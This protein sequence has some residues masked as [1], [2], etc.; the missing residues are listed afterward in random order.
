MKFI[1]SII[2]SLN[3]LYT[4]AQ[5]SASLVQKPLLDILH[6][7]EKKYH[8]SFSFSH[9]LI[10]KKTTTVQLH[11]LHLGQFLSSVAEECG[12]DFEEIDEKDYVIT[13][14]PPR[15]KNY[16]INLI[17]E[18]NQPIYGVYATCGNKMLGSIS[19]DDGQMKFS[20]KA[21]DGDSI[22]FHMIGYYEQTI[23]FSF[24]STQTPYTTIQL[25]ADHHAL[26]LDVVEVFITEGI[27]TGVDAHN[28]MIKTDELA[29]LPGESG[30]DVLNSIKLM[31]GVRSPDS[32]I[33]NLFIRGSSPDQSTIIY[34]NIPLYHRGHYFGA[35]SPFN[36]SMIDEIDIY[37]GGGTSDYG[38]KVGGIIDIQSSDKAVDSTTFTVGVNS[39]YL[40]GHTKVPLKKN[41]VAL[42]LS[43]RRSLPHK[44]NLPK[45]QA[46]NDMVFKASEIERLQT[47]TNDSLNALNYTFEDYKSKLIWDP[48]QD[49]HLSFSFIHVSN[50]LEF[51]KTKS[52]TVLDKN[53]SGFSNFGGSFRWK[54]H[55]N[56][57]WS[58][59]LVFSAQEYD[60]ISTVTEQLNDNTQFVQIDNRNRIKEYTAKLEFSKYLNDIDYIDFGFKQAHKNIT[61]FNKTY[62]GNT[63]ES[64][65]DSLSNIGN[66]HT[67]Y[68][69]YHFQHAKNFHFTLGTRANYFSEDEKFNIEPRFFMSYKLNDFVLLK[70]SY[71]RNKQF[72][73]QII[74][75]GFDNIGV[76]NRI[77]VLSGDNIKVMKGDQMS[78]GGLF[79][80]GV[81]S[82]DVEFFNKYIENVIAQDFN[83][84]SIYYGNGH[85][86]GL[87]LVLKRSWGKVDTWV[88]YTYNNNKET[89]DDLNMKVEAEFNQPHSIKLIGMI[90]IKKRFKFSIGWMF[91]AGSSTEYYQLED[92]IRLERGESIETSSVSNNELY[93]IF[94]K[95]NLGDRLP[96]QHELDI[97][98][99]YDLFKKCSYVN[100][101]I[102]LSILNLYN[103]KNYAD[104]TLRRDLT[105]N[106]A[107]RYSTGFAPNLNVNI[108]W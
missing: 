70:S 27:N 73:R 83:S 26:N 9:D 31:P 74:D 8:V 89:Y 51:E 36:P 32:K 37:L 6:K 100:G 79:K 19:H 45:I 72:V 64:S 59:K 69:N 66:I 98:F 107:I 87:D 91:S 44:W 86:Y 108:S 95:S 77:W 48:N 40:M 29:L 21:K 92:A 35:I 47:I 90:P 46:I 39:L 23:P 16:I 82:F 62:D 33:G 63:V 54:T 42:L 15:L 22:T 97:S 60:F 24:L 41:K 76:E 10:S 13:V 20:F 53:I 4:I 104:L 28:I 55:I 56:N 68:F 93:D 49:H 65:I 58:S 67:A 78:L 101:V 12:L 5:S 102:G 57:T 105:A 2:L 94:L 38:G 80:K 7:A 88:S 11:G 34:D 96:H 3:C 17:D 43:A 25:K 81:W 106:Y 84:Q 18:R 50:K 103:R 75:Q 61:Q 85:Y 52:A 30:R 71:A 14:H 99:T 1:L